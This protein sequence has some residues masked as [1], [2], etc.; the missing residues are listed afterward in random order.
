MSCCPRC[1][2]A[3]SDTPH[4]YG[5]ATP[6]S[7]VAPRLSAPLSKATGAWALIRLEAVKSHFEALLM[8]S[9]HGTG[10]GLSPMSKTRKAI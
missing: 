3:R 9:W 1:P 8:Q 6:P 10:P 7:I 4:L 2:G 5:F